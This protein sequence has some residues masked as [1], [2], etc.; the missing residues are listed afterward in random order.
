LNGTNRFPEIEGVDWA[1]LPDE[2]SGLAR[3]STP[4]GITLDRTGALLLVSLCDA[5]LQDRHFL[6]EMPGAKE[7]LGPIRQRIGS[8][9]GSHRT[10]LDLSLLSAWFFVASLQYASRLPDFPQ[11]VV[12]DFFK[13]IGKFVRDALGAY[14]TIQVSL[15]L[16]WDASYGRVW[17][18]RGEGGVGNPL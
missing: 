17:L 5:L 2:W 1:T 18:Y 3:D 16:G 14:P 8:Q 11:A 13:T 6:H 12:E 7:V 10:H 15:D 9:F 4:F